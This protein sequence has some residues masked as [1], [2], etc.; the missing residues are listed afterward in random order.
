MNRLTNEKKTDERLRE[1]ARKSSGPQLP[2]GYQENI[3]DLLTKLQSGQQKKKPA[4][5]VVWKRAAAVF[6]VFLVLGTVGV[7]ATGNFG[8]KHLEEMGETQKDEFV[9]DVNEADTEHDS[10]SR[11]LT[12]SE[13]ER[14]E[15]LYLEYE[16]KGR[17]PEHTLEV[18]DTKKDKAENELYFVVE[19]STFYLPE[20]ELTDEELLELVDFYRKRDYSLG[21][22]GQGR[23]EASSEETTDENKQQELVRNYLKKLCDPDLFDSYQRS[24]MEGQ[25][26]YVDIYTSDGGIY[27]VAYQKET[28]QLVYVSRELSE[29][30]SADIPVD[31]QLYRDKYTAIKDVL[32]RYADEKEIK[33]GNIVYVTTEEGLL[34]NGTYSAIFEMKDG[35]AY[36][37]KYSCALDGVCNVAYMEDAATLQEMEKNNSLSEEKLGYKQKKLEME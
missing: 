19:N 12:E 9:E 16:T 2:D 36:I 6:A 10:Y 37:L 34:R 1:L 22:A 31:E 26:V 14:I 7:Y 18:C 27:G 29:E 20:R 4:V 17:F 32:G 23:Q 24:E 5:S 25:N 28:G 35:S 3:D 15:K 30:E 33:S 8:R 21:E 11:D 13:E